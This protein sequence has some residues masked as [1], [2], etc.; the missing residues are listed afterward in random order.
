MKKYYNLLIVSAIFLGAL[1]SGCASV[2]PSDDVL[3]IIIKSP[4]IVNNGA[5]V[6]VSIQLSDPLKE[7]QTLEVIVN[8]ETGHVIS[9]EN[10]A[11]L[12][13]FSSR[14]RMKDSGSIRVRIKEVD[15]T[16]VMAERSVTVKKYD[17]DVADIGDNGV[18]H[19]Q[20]VKDNKIMLMFANYMQ[21]DNYLE[22]VT[23]HTSQGDIHFQNTVLVA[24]PPY[25]SVGLD[26]N[27]GDFTV[28]ARLANQ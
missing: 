6:P 9:V 20:R 19:R 23:L 2:P 11:A 15:K 22:H 3:R 13:Y 21:P 28:E 16:I 1:L 5:T 12:S 8:N 27:A 10:G 14:Y 26:G 4:D 17:D 24:A 18:K 25:L 7:T